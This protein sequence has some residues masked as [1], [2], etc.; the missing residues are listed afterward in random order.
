MVIRNPSKISIFDFLLFFGVS[1]NVSQNYLIIYQCYRRQIRDL[2]KFP[3]LR[4]FALIVSAHPYCAQKF[5][6]RHASMRAL[7]NKKYNER[8][9]GPLLWLCLDLTILDTVISTSSKH[10]HKSKFGKL[11]KVKISVHGKSKSCHLT[12]T[13]HVKLWSPGNIW[14]YLHNRPTSTKYD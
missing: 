4:T 12:A 13:R 2:Q 1:T 3:T 7:S 9:D 8:A 10:E 14:N 6:P 5:T 11:K